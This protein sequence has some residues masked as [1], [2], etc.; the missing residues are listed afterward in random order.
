MAN[1]ELFDG[2]PLNRGELKTV[3]KL[4]FAVAQA[5]YIKCSFGVYNINEIRSYRVCTF[6]TRK[7]EEIICILVIIECKHI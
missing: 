3:E 1:R 5:A 7:K 2:G 6:L 4:V